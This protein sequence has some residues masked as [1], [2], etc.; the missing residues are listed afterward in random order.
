MILIIDN[1]DSFVYNIYR[2][3]RLLGQ[4]AEVV[5]NDKIDAQRVIAHGYS[6]IIISPGPQ[7]PNEAGNTLSII[8]DC[9]PIPMLGVCLGHQAIGQAFGGKVLRAPRPIHGQTEWVQHRGNGIF[10]G[11][12]QPMQV[13]RYH[14]LVVD[15]ET[16]SPALEVLATC[17][18]NLIMALK[19]K[20]LPIWGV[21]FHPESIMTIGGFRLLTNFLRLTGHCVAEPIPESDCVGTIR[22]HETQEAVEPWDEKPWWEVP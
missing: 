4:D 22:F 15:H 8:R 9:Q 13:A 5:R 18:P 17:Q 21:Q 7:T 19:H 11:L 3:L 1:Y 16:L 10:E 6:A 2:Y 20:Q 14:S 12:P